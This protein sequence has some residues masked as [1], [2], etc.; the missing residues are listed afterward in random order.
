MGWFKNGECLQFWAI[1]REKVVINHERFPKFSD[2]LASKKGCISQPPQDT[3]RS[4]TLHAVRAPRKTCLVF[5]AVVAGDHCSCHADREIMVK[6]N[7]PAS[8]S[9][10]VCGLCLS[11][12]E[13]AGF[14]AKKPEIVQGLSFF[15]CLAV[16][17]L[18]ALLDPGRV[19]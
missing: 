11:S 13:G 18:I 4:F 16:C 15:L 3:E 9:K 10:A 8:F 17:G 1:L 12:V 7:T 2:K 5:V 14:T 6:L 19:G